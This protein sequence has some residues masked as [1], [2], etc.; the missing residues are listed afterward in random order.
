MHVFD[1][2]VGEDIYIG[3]DCLLLI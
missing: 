2:D 3:D 1:S